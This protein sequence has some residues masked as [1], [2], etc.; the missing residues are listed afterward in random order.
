LMRIQHART[1]GTPD[2]WWLKKGLEMCNIRL[3]PIL[4]RPYWEGPGPFW[5]RLGQCSELDATFLDL[6]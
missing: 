2:L 1:T 6:H 3:P 4:Y 5:V